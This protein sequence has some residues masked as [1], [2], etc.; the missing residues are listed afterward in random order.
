MEHIRCNQQMC[1]LEPLA[2][3]EEI[4]TVRQM[5]Q[6]HA[7]HTQSQRAF[8]I[9]AL[10]EQYVPQFV[11]VHPRDYK[12]MVACL[13]KAHAQ[14]LNGDEAVMVAFEENARDLARVGGG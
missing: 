11:K 13:E 5:I 12:R 7:D 9:L 3:A 8:K 2:N 4:E 14:G 6:R 1:Q 10:W